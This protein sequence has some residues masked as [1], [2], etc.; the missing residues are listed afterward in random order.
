MVLI[1]PVQVGHALRRMTTQALFLAGDT[2]Y[3][4]DNAG[5]QYGT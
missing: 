4:Q 1:W 2:Q 3:Q 5:T